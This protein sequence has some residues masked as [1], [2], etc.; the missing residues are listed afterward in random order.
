MHLRFLLSALL[1]QPPCRV[2]K[3]AS[4]LLSFRF[5]CSFLFHNEPS[6]EAVTGAEMEPTTAAGADTSAGLNRL[7]GTNGS[8]VFLWS[9]TLGHQ[10]KQ[11]VAYLKSYVNSAV[12]QVKLVTLHFQ[13]H[14]KKVKCA[15][16]APKLF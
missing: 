12:N 15:I 3:Q 16:E 10:T 7:T 13:S 11:E 2:M 14:L 1:L 9:V 6:E 4:T 8:P 5:F